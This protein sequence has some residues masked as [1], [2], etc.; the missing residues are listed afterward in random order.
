LHGKRRKNTHTP[1]EPYIKVFV[2]TK[3]S[4]CCRPSLLKGVNYGWIGDCAELYELRVRER[5]EG[6]EGEMQFARDRVDHS[7][8]QCNLLCRLD[9]TSPNEEGLFLSC[10]G[11]I[12]WG[13]FCGSSYGQLW[14]RGWNGV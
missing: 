2:Y 5:D 13:S 7:G 12:E 6:A 3:V 11:G 10:V 14:R 9:F 4:I 8:V 1:E